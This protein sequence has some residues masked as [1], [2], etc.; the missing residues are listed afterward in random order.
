MKLTSSGRRAVLAASLALLAALGACGGG[1][2][3]DSPSANL[4][5]TWH[6]VNTRLQDISGWNGTLPD[7]TL[8]G[9]SGA[10]TAHLQPATTA[11]LGDK[12]AIN[13]EVDY[14]DT[15]FNGPTS[16]TS[17]YIDQ[18]YSDA[19]TGSTLAVLHTDGGGTVQSFEV[20]EVYTLPTAAHAGDHGRV[21]TTHLYASSTSADPTGHTVID[22]AVAAGSEPHS[23]QV[24]Y[25]S[26]Q[27]DA[28]NVLQAIETRID[29][30]DRN[31]NVTYTARERK[32][33]ATD[34]TTVTSDVQRNQHVDVI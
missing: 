20:F 5:A 23:L 6:Q 16:T 2:E 11:T 21:T 27:Y 15:L 18:V 32:T 26:R 7:G 12:A 14:T 34:G 4:Q 1:G 9:I 31:G 24:T 17:T 10:S 30:L 33:F 13:R 3:D 25:T 29:T 22:Y 28:N 19:G 8:I